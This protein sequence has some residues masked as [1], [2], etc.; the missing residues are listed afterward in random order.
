MAK[1]PEKLHHVRETEVLFAR[2]RL[3]APASLAKLDRLH[4]EQARGEAAICNLQYASLA[5][6]LIGGSRRAGFVDA[7][8]RYTMLYVEHMRTEK[9]EVLPLAERA[10][11][12]TDR[13]EIDAAFGGNRDPLAGP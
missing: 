7:L 10:P 9:R 8:E 3:S 5:C 13:Q 6:R 2:L 1:F 11:T 12:D 4:R